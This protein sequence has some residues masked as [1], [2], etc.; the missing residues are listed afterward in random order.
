MSHPYKTDGEWEFPFRKDIKI[1][2]QVFFHALTSTKK[3]VLLLQ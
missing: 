2:G 1:N 3:I